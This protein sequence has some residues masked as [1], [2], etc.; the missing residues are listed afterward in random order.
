MLNHSHFNPISQGLKKKKQKKV[1]F[2][3]VLFLNRQA[4]LK[5][6]DVIQ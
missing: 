4:A 3:L 1:E 5:M 2:Q 6:L